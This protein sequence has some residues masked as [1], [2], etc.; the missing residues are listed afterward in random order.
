[1]LGI[2][3]YQCKSFGKR[4]DTCSIYGSVSVVDSNWARHLVDQVQIC[5][6]HLCHEFHELN[7]KKGSEPKGQELGRVSKI[8]NGAQLTH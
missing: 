7:L 3:I 1:M 8:E 2:K 5:S 6:F 4:H